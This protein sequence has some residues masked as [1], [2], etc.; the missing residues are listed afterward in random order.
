MGRRM[1]TGDRLAHHVFKVWPRAYTLNDVATVPSV[2]MAMD[3]RRAD[4]DMGGRSAA[5]IHTSRSMITE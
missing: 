4:M 1:A 3:E 2:V 5:H